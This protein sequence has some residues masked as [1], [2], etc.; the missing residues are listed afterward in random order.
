MFRESG[1]ALGGN[2][3]HRARSSNTGRPLANDV[4]RGPIRNDRELLGETDEMNCRTVGLMPIGSTIRTPTLLA[5][6]LVGN[7][8]G[9]GKQIFGTHGHRKGKNLSRSRASTVHRSVKRSCRRPPKESSR[10]YLLVAAPWLR[11]A[12]GENDFLHEGRR[13]GL[14]CR[15]LQGMNVGPEAAQRP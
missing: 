9:C 1:E 3:R 7:C 14:R 5:G 2:Q 6:G 8:D 11:Q 4:N 12:A 13:S 10:G 15:L